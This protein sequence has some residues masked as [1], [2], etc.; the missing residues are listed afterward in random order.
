MEML[1]WKKPFVGLVVGFCD[2]VKI[3]LN[4]AGNWIRN[5]FLLCLVSW[6]K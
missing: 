1:R 2:S 4:E 5:G 6:K 3:Y